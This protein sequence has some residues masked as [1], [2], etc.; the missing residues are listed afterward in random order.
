MKGSSRK[1]KAVELL[2]H[3]GQNYREVAQQ[4]GVTEVTLRR[5]R[6]DPVFADAVLERSRDLLKENLPDIY[7]VLFEKAKEGQ[8]QHIRLVL[9]HLEFL[10]ELRSTVESAQ[11]SFVWRRN[12]DE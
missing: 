9:E 6:K 5:W 10:E 2:A 11:I 12:E 3:G 4:V 1:A 7:S 8:H